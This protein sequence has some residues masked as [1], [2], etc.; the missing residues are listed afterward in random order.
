MF[1]TNAESANYTQNGFKKKKAD[2]ID[3]DRLVDLWLEAEEIGED[4]E[5]VSKQIGVKKSTV[6][7]TISQLRKAGVPLPRLNGKNQGRPKQ[8][9]EEKQA[10]ID[11]L[12]AKCAKR[13]FKFADDKDDPTDETR[14]TIAASMTD[15]APS[16]VGE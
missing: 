3:R 12:A 8:S 7:T 6:T 14:E 9:A 1:T 2:A 13:G 4:T 11:R 10:E 15:E 5:W 16:T